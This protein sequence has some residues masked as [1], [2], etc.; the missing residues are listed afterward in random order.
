MLRFQ[1]N[2]EIDFNNFVQQISNIADKFEKDINTNQSNTANLFKP[3]LDIT[4]LNDKVIIEIE[5][6]GVDKKDVNIKINGEG[7]LTISGIKNKNTDQDFTKLRQERKYGNFCRSLQL[8]PEI[9]IEKVDAKY[10]DGILTLTL[11]K[12]QP[13]DIEINID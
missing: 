1:F 10:L 8:S 11:N 7:S 13:K 3:E 6:P 12:K 4:E 5:L 2:P 9:D